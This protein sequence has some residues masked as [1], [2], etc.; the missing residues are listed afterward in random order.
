MILAAGSMVKS[1]KW[2]M[3]KRKRID[4]RHE[5]EEGDGHCHSSF[6][7]GNG[8]LLKELDADSLFVVWD[9]ADF[10]PGLDYVRDCGIAH[11][12]DHVG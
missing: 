11:I 5:N 4:V 1:L 8:L 7:T 9:S 12:S 3:M 6:I 2:I 10:L